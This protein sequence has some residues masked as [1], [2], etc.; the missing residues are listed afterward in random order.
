MF[1]LFSFL[2]TF[3]VLVTVK[4]ASGKTVGTAADQ[5]TV[6]GGGVVNW[7]PKTAITLPAAKL[8][9]VYKHGSANKPALYTATAELTVA[10]KVVDAVTETFGVRKTAWTGPEGFALNGKPFKILGNANHQD[11]AAVGV[12]VPDHL[13]W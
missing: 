3:S 5:G 2:Q 9:H 8:W 13:Q 4:D 6:D 11:F 7:S 1:A 12:A 10:G